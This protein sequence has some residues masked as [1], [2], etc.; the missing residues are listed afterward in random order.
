MILLALKRIV[1]RAGT[2]LFF[3]FEKWGFILNNGFRI[4]RFKSK[5]MKFFFLLAAFVCLFSCTNIVVQNQPAKGQE[6]FPDFM[7]GKF[8]LVYPESFRELLNG[9]DAGETQIIEITAKE[10]SFRTGDSIVRQVLNDSVAICKIKSDYYLSIGS[11]PDLTVFMVKKKE[12]NM[13]LFPMFCM[14]EVKESDLKKY[15]TNI[16]S[17]QEGEFSV[18]VNPKKLKSYFDSGLPS[19]DPFLLKRI[20]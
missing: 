2:L 13:E 4:L 9:A 14:S 17:D 6:E 15:F 7:L 1:R 11:E 18:K 19:K 3:H 8:E 5:I 10:M 16:K 20:P 12:T